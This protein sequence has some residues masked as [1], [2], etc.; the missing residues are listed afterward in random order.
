MENFKNASFIDDAEKMYDFVCLPK[1]RFL[2]SYSYL[3]EEEYVNTKKLFI[4]EDVSMQKGFSITVSLTSNKLS[5]L[6]DALDQELYDQG[7]YYN[8]C[9]NDAERNVVLHHIYTA[10]NLLDK[11]NHLWERNFK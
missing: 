4:Q 6:M 10:V 7:E 9:D 8:Y 3:T 1:E 2:E 5:T 11:F